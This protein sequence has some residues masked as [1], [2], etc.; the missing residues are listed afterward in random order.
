M[1]TTPLVFG[2][3]RTH[4][5]LRHALIAPDGHVPSSLPGVD[6]ATTVVLISREMGAR[7]T[8]ALL[9]FETDGS[10]AFPSNEIEAFAY[11]VRGSVRAEVLG[12]T[13]TLDAGGYLFV[14][15][16][17]A[18]KLN[19]PAEGTRVNLFFKKYVHLDGVVPPQTVVGRED[20]VSGQPYLDDEDARLQTLLPNH[21]SFDMAVN[22]FKYNPGALL[23]FVETH[24]MEH[25]L[26]MLEG[27]GIYRLEDRWYPVTAGDCLWMAPYCPQWFTA[28]G[29]SPARYLYYKDVNRPVFP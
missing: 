10:A 6:Q 17:Q 24:I 9:T 1:T 8:Q 25:G 29:K 15:A 2:D 20:E 13:L 18:W 14:P 11:V 21:P 22:I 19:A 4:I 23:P 3:S 27:K 28:M 12:D 26:L 7:F 5:G 16:G